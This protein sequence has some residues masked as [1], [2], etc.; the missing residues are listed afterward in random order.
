MM[1]TQP[2]FTTTTS[3]DYAETRPAVLVR[4]GN[5]TDAERPGDSH[6]AFST[7]GGATWFQG[8][9]PSG[10]D[11][12]GTVAASADGSRFVWAPGDPGRQV[13]RS[14]GF[15]TSWTAAI[16][17]PASAV[18][19]SDRVD[20][21]RFYGVAGG[22]FHVSTDGG[23]S[24]TATAATGL[25]SGGV[26]FKAVPGRTGDIWLAGEGGLWR[27]TDAGA[28][29]TRLGGVTTAGNVGF[30]K[31]APGQTYPAVF[32]IGTVDGRHGVYRSDDAG[33]SW[34]RINDDRHQYGN[35]GE[36]ITGDPRVYGRVY[37]GTN[38]RGILYADR[39]GPAPTTPP[40]TPPVTPPPTTTPPTTTPPVTTPPTTTPPVPTPPVTTAPAGS[41]AVTYTVAN[42][43]SGGFQGSVRVTNRSATAVTGW[44]LRWSFPNGQVVSQLWNGTVTQ[45]GAA[46]TVTNAGWNGTLAANGGSAEVGFQASW[47]GTNSRPSTFTLNGVTCAAG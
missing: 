32:V 24:F 22:R 38:G 1:F 5:F 27:S 17:I 26:K 14:V 45:S 41:C 33:G 6:V 13:V 37:L 15:G 42:Q 46:V 40:T 47:T 11:S 3:L 34:V 16:G 43:W 10:V 4:A 19:E 30:G 36:A 35:A 9:E 25:P 39:T 7:D 20:P 8:T 18:V 21:N 31:A 28:S 29:F 12:G 23:A 44:T 2:H